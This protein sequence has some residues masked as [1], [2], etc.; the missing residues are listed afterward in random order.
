MAR[1]LGFIHRWEWKSRYTAAPNGRRVAVEVFVP[2]EEEGCRMPPPEIEREW[3]LGQQ[4]YTYTVTAMR[5]EKP[6]KTRFIVMK[7]R[8]EENGQLWL[9]FPT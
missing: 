5:R 2:I 8:K 4:G 9:P 3:V 7:R 6:R 1:L